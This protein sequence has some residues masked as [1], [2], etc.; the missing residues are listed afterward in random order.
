MPTGV[1]NK[2]ADCLLAKVAEAFYS[3]RSGSFSR[4]DKG[5]RLHRSRG[6]QMIDTVSH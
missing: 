2:K 4:Y 1:L 6:G 5:R 3:E